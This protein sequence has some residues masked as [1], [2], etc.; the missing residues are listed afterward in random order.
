[1]GLNFGVVI[2]ADLLE[3]LLSKLQNFNFG[4]N[5]TKYYLLGFLIFLGI[6]YLLVNYANKT[7]LETDLPT[8]FPEEIEP[9]TPEIQPFEQSD[10]LENTFSEAELIDT[11]VYEKNAEGF[12]EVNW[13]HL[14]SVKFNEKYTEEVQAYVPYPL[15][16]PSIHRL[17]GQK[18]QIRGYVIPIEETG[19][20]TMIVLSAN[21]FSSC[22]FCG[23]AGPETI[24]DIQP[25]SK[26][27]QVLKQDDIISFRGKLR[28]NDSDLYY[29]NYILEDAELR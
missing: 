28:L 10:S 29:L 11:V 22:F 5:S 23:M 9:E 21:P 14:S 7:I 6:G 15:F 25:K 2:F 19:D 3:N 18:I 4:M 1:M 24:M 27:N 13:G 16:H 12:Y 8:E 17:N 26:I 20:E